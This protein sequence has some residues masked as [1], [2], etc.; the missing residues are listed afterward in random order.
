VIHPATG[1]YTSIYGY[2]SPDGT[3]S[4]SWIDYSQHA[5]RC[6]FPERV[7]EAHCGMAFDWTALPAGCETPEETDVIEENTTTETPGEKTD[8]D[9]PACTQPDSDPDRDGWGW[10]NDRSCRMASHSDARASETS[11]Q[12]T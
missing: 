6:K 2:I 4:M 3:P 10:E 7:I 12:V 9:Y 5:W 8:F 1:V 11:H